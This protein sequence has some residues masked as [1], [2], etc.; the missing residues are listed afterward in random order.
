MHNVERF[1]ELVHERALGGATQQVHQHFGI[2]IGV[3]N[4]T[5]VFQLTPQRRAIRQIAVV[6]QSHI[7]IM[8]AEDERLDVVG[9]A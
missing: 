8:E 1:L 2:G 4:R 3:E 9:A 7:A 5:L 6:A